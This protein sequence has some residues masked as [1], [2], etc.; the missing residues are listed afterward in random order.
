MEAVLIRG[1]NGVLFHRQLRPPSAAPDAPGLRAL[2]EQALDQHPSS[3]SA[4]A[5]PQ[6]P[7]GAVA[8]TLLAPLLHT[9]ESTGRAVVYLRGCGVHWAVLL[10]PTTDIG[11]AFVAAGQFLHDWVSALAHYWT[12]LTPAVLAREAVQVALIV[13]ELACGGLPVHVY[14]NQLT[15]TLPVPDL[16]SRLATTV[17]G[18]VMAPASGPAAARTSVSAPWRRALVKHTANEVYVDVDERISGTV[19]LSSQPSHQGQ[20]RSPATGARGSIRVHGYLHAN[21]KLSGLP[22]LDVALAGAPLRSLSLAAQHDCVVAGSK[23]PRP[24]TA[25]PG[26]GLPAELA[27]TPPEGKATLVEYAHHP[28]TSPDDLDAD[29]LA[30]A[31]AWV[32]VKAVRD[33]A[34][35][36]RITVTVTL[37]DP[38]GARVGSG[39]AAASW[40]WTAADH[41][42]LRV[43]VPPQFAVTTHRCSR[44]TTRANTATVVDWRPNA[45]AAAGAANGGGNGASG[46]AAVA[47]GGVAAA[48]LSKLAVSAPAAAAPSLARGLGA[49]AAGISSTAAAVGGMVSSSTGATNGNGRALLGTSSASSAAA[50]V[51][52]LTLFV[53]PAQVDAATPVLGAGGAGADTARVPCV[54]TAALSGAVVGQTATGLK[55]ARV[56]VRREEYKVYQGVRYTTAVDG[57]EYRVTC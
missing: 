6:S 48:A 51:P 30:S 25:L 33:P 22:I 29:L 38:T 24:A 55:V 54:V 41:V 36:A 17:M 20:K 50:S 46:G 26:S 18:Q 53:A 39:P 8:G 32:R 19:H 45:A 5:I 4:A 28:T 9:H 11:S 10:S 44:G 15:A 35:P 1:E 31:T 42:A 14:A 16:L 52:T 7:S 49:A 47:V 56:G 40:D 34:S 21:T 23:H 3:R 2:L 12:P 13:D 37:G 43:T 57:L 27:C